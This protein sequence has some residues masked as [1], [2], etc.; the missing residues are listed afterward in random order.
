[1]REMSRRRRLLISGNINRAPWSIDHR[2]SQRMGTSLST[3][4]GGCDG[5]RGIHVHFIEIEEWFVCLSH[6]TLTQVL[7]QRSVWDMI[8]LLV[9]LAWT[10]SGDIQKSNRHEHPECWQRCLVCFCSFRTFFFGRRFRFGKSVG[11]CE[12]HK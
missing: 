7:S 10:T 9:T 8:K 4:G 12:G 11:Q 6:H 3:H 2:V 5:L 1:M